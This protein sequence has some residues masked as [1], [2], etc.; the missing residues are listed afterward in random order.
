MSATLLRT[1]ISW[2]LALALATASIFTAVVPAQA[3]TTPSSGQLIRGEA[4]PAVYYIGADGFRYV[5][6]TD[7]TFFTWYENFND[8][9]WISDVELGKIQIGGNVTY[10][11]GV[12]M[13]KI[14]SDPRTYAIGK[15]GELR[16][17][18]SQDIA[19][20]LYGSNWNSKVDDI[21][22]S[23]FSNYT[24]GEPIMSASDYSS[25]TSMSNSSTINIDKDIEAY[26]IMVIEDTGY[27][28]ILSINSK[29]TI[30]AGGAVRFSNSGSK[31]HTATG[32]DGTWG[33]GSIQAG[34][35]YTLRFI[36]AGTYSF[37]DSY[38]DTLT[39]TIIVE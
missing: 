33:T 36:E 29:I 16:H 38:D 25:T 21:P 12:R 26:K 6:P 27:H 4:F 14:T 24:I 17:I 28:G 7:K 11:P 34:E 9:I 31:A 32:D 19:S 20:S 30:N 10:R 18:T 15:D 8:V 3:T 1:P 2:L 5:F 39:G 22:D 35:T 13:A 23:F 37:Y